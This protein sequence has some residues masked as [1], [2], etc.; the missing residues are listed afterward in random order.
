M[1]YV[2]AQT[3]LSQT[4]DLSVALSLPLSLTLY[5]YVIDDAK[6]VRQTAIFHSIE[7]F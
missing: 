5:S 4:A 7:I 1:A 6:L 2:L 3:I